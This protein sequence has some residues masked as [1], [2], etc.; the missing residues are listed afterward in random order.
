[1]DRLGQADAFGRPQD[2]PAGSNARWHAIAIGLLDRLR[3][4][5]PPIAEVRD[6]DVPPRALSCG[7]HDRARQGPLARSARPGDDEATRAVLAHAAPS[8][9][10]SA[11]RARIIWLWRRGDPL[12][13]PTKDQNSSISTSERARSRA[14]SAVTASARAP[15]R[16]IQTAMVS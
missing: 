16:R 13:L 1:L 10:G 3:V 11:L 5:R 8:V 15:K 6:A 14:R 4:R 7:R 9:A 2:I 12:F